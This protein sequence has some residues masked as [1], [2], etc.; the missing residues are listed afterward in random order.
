MKQAGIFGLLIV[1]LAATSACVPRRA[2]QT[3]NVSTVSTGQQL[4]DLK[5]ALDSGAI[6]QAEFDKKQKEILK[7]G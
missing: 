6:S 3:T 7:N 5:A 2:K 4:T 1:A